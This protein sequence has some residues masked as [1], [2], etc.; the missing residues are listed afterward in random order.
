MADSSLNLPPG[1]RKHLRT[2]SRI[3]VQLQLDVVGTDAPMELAVWAGL[4]AGDR[5]TALRT[6]AR[7]LASA[8]L[9]E[10]EDRD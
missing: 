5:V 6:L 10:G 9:S 2:E 7:L 3:A 8:A 1:L 4:P